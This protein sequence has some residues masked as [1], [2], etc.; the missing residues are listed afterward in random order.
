MRQSLLSTEQTLFVQEE[1]QTLSDLLLN[2]SD[3]NLSKEALTTLQKAIIQLDELF[4]IVAVGE[5]N[6][7]KSAL[8]NAL[9]GEKVLPEGVTPTTARVTLVRY[10]DKVTEQIVDEGFAIYTYPM[11]L[12]KDLNIVDSP[13]T[14]A[15]IRQHERLTNEFV[16]RS[17][18]V[19]F[20]TSADRP[21]TESERQ[22][23][24]KIV[25]WGKK[26]VIIVNKK[27]IFET[28]EAMDE[29]RDFV[30]KNVGA[31][32]GEEPKLYMVSARQAQ[33]AALA[34]DS[35]E[36]E[37]LRQQS[38]INPLE[39]YIFNTL[40][41]RARLQLKLNSPL[42]V[43]DRFVQVAAEMTDAESGD[44]K[45]DRVTVDSLEST[46]SG[47]ERELAKEL[48]PRIAEIENIMQR[49]ELRGL[50]FF[51]TNLRLTNIANLAKGD[52]IRAKFEQEVLADLPQEIE[53][54][55]HRLIDWL[56]D[57]DLNEWHQVM[58]YLQRRQ[59]VNA[60]HIVGGVN[61]P[62]SA[63]RH[64]LIDNV[65]RHVRTIVES[66][67][68]TKEASELATFVENAVAQTALFEVGAVGLGAL[69]ASALMSS[70]MDITG[71]LAAGTLAIVG[72]FVIP[73][74]RTQAKTNFKEKV[75]KM[76]ET[77]IESLS[78]TFERES[79]SAV[80]RMRES[81]APYTRFVHS[82]EDR[83]AKN[84]SILEEAKAKIGSLRSRIDAIL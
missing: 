20:I 52:K 49:F 83:I 42:G 67:D 41:D 56:V 28:Q 30:S 53:Q 26:V 15:I 29:V 3:F 66:Y 65:G 61:S 63:R 59:A 34:T 77:L 22:F 23:L 6:A 64:E 4:L 82:E 11:E 10:G 12:L 2:L 51:D 47:Y 5:F 78:H 24:E 35:V 46:I 7:G 25:S 57:K 71:I 43:A 44:L 58:G 48:A 14:N 31:I 36:K 69:V 40:D 80:N 73:Y 72:L 68:R 27:D 16:P 62:Q 76:R 13:G 38:G 18:L 17:D 21:L 81:V 37:S 39:S 60:D 33:K 54:Q 45:E 79:E 32:L 1:K 70:A 19:L 84:R 74:K 75:E 55:L 8:V 50:D 9:L